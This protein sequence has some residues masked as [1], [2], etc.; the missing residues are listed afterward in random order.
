MA[1]GAGWYSMS[2]RKVSEFEIDLRMTLVMNP[3]FW[4]EVIHDLSLSYNCLKC[5][6]TYLLLSKTHENITWTSA[7]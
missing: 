2:C 3:G 6:A 1:G 7:Q 5:V 4:G